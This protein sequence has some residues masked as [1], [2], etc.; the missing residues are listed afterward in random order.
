M[1]DPETAAEDEQDWQEYLNSIDG[2]NVVQDGEVDH[3]M[4]RE[5]LGR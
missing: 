1:I 4:L 5:L 2:Y 3:E